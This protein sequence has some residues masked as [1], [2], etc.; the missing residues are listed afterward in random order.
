MVARTDIPC[1]MVILGGNDRASRARWPA[2]AVVIARAPFGTSRD[3]P[4]HPAGQNRNGHKSNRTDAQRSTRRQRRSINLLLGALTRPN[5]WRYGP[6]SML[7]APCWL[8]DTVVKILEELHPE[9]LPPLFLHFFPCSFLSLVVYIR[10]T[11]G[12]K[13]SSSW[14]LE[15]FIG[16]F[17]GGSAI[18]TRFNFTRNIKR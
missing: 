1:A 10:T 12:N 3:V 16:I 13:A 2:S 9:E 7:N 18:N 15:E 5:E 11:I 14:L 6:T 17:V 8:V 4:F